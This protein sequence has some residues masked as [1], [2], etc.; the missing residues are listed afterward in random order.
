MEIETIVTVNAHSVTSVFPLPG[1]GV[2]L[3]N[4]TAKLNNTLHNIVTKI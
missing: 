2:D 3:P 1:G 4:D